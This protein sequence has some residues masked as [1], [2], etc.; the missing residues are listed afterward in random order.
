MGVRGR[1]FGRWEGRGCDEVSF[2]WLF[3]FRFFSLLDFLD[4]EKY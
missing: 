3:C 4:W 2:V 1:R